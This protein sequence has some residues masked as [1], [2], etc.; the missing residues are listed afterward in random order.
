MCLVPLKLDLC[1]RLVYSLRW[2]EG[3]GWRKIWSEWCWVDC[4][5]LLV[6]V[7]VRQGTRMAFCHLNWFRYNILQ[8]FDPGYECKVCLVLRI[9]L[10]GFADFK[11]WNSLSLNLWRMQDG[12]LFIIC[13]HISFSS[14]MLLNLK[15][16]MQVSNHW[17]MYC[18]LFKGNSG[19]L[20]WILLV[21]L[22]LYKWLFSM[23]E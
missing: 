21:V 19:I 15:R 1:L 10:S 17:F 18:L 8:E 16:L 5:R 23:D 9:A 7:S 13:L 12:K 6:C 20:K 2:R 22:V 14:F 4:S 3:Y 11:N